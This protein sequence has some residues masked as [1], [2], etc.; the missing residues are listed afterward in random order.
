M[1]LGL[2]ADV[3]VDRAVESRAL[4]QQQGGQLAFESVAPGVVGEV[5][6]ALA[7]SGDGVDHAADELAHAGLAAW[8]AERPAKILGHDHVSGGLRPGA[9]NLDVALFKN[10]PPVFAGDHG[11]AQLP[12]DLAKGIDAGMAKETLQRESGARCRLGSFGRF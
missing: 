6:L 3:E 4:G 11:R 10:H 7:P 5:A 1:W 12:F 2:D 9:R 8:S